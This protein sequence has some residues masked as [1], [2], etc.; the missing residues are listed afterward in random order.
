LPH[1]SRACSMWGGGVTTAKQLT[2]LLVMLFVSAHAQDLPVLNAPCGCEED[3]VSFCNYDYGESGFCE[4][5][6]DF[7][8]PVECFLDGLPRRGAL[9][10]A[11]RCFDLSPSPP[12]GCE[13]DRVSFCN[14]DYGES[15]FCESCREFS[16]PDECLEVGL[17]GLGML[18]CAVRCFDLFPSPTP[19]PSP[20]P[21]PDPVESSPPPPP[22]TQL[23]T[24][25]FV[26]TTADGRRLAEA[27]LA[28]RKLSEVAAFEDDLAATIAVSLPCC[29]PVENVKVGRRKKR[30]GKGGGRL[31][32]EESLAINDYDYPCEVLPTGDVTAATIVASVEAPEFTAELVEEFADT[33]VIEAVVDVTIELVPF[34]PSSP[35]AS[36]APSPPPF[37]PP[38][39]PHKVL[40]PD[41]QRVDKGRHH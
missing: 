4:S 18:D 11:A 22:P 36:I 3:R 15:G 33:V 6:R 34:P 8:N 25:N 37:P 16:N 20:S 12:C 32:S 29:V 30:R 38:F 14:F 27:E 17:S 2:L 19:S 28:G 40:E 24:V 23:E 39:P 21:S 26:V 5:C 10:C 31:L 7:S 9:D 13:E 35:T 41:R 1:P